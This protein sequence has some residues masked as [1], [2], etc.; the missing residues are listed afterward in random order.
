MIEET[1]VLVHVIQET[2]VL[3]LHYR[4]TCVVAPL[5]TRTAR[6]PECTHAFLVGVVAPHS[7][8]CIFFHSELLVV[9]PDW[10]TSLC[11]NQ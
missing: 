11:C 10:K 4:E 2:R 8:C 5:D 3:V 6:T 9:F 1:C 7:Q